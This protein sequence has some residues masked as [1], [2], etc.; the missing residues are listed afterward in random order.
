MPL[1]S[2]TR[3]KPRSW[4]F[5]PALGIYI[6]RSKRQLRRAE[7]FFGG[8]LASGPGLALWTVT[9]WQ[10]EAAMRAYRDSLA[11]RSAMPKLVEICS[12][13]A[14]AHWPSERRS[15][16]PPPEAAARMMEGRTSRVKYPTCHHEAGETW[17][18][19]KVPTIGVDLPP[20]ESCKG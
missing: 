7:G 14:V 4:R 16:P 8:Y 6:W 1:V 11:H 2:V 18:D 10:D 12:E 19:R 20:S 17:P 3:L 9:V 15:P 13:A 5:L